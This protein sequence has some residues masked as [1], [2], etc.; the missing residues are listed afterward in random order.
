MRFAANLGW[1]FQE[2]PFLDRFAAARRAG[3]RGVEFAQPYEYP[4]AEVAARLR[5]NDLA[6]VLINLPMGDKAKGDF[7]IACRPGREAEFR[8]GVARGIEYAHSI[9]VPKLNCISGTAKPGEDREA[10]RATLVSNLRLAAREFKAAGLELVIE[11]INTHDIPG[12]FLSRSPEALPLIE[13]VGV[14]NLGLQCDLYHTVMMGDDPAAILRQCWP[15]IRH[16]QFADAPGRGEPG[17]GRIDFAPL[18]ALIEELGYAGWVSAEYRP[19]KPTPETVS[20][21]LS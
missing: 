6:C 7:G 21:F 16:I 18:F 9:G 5:D 1:L 12:F 10:M 19:S 8:E 2:H 4:A 13:E 3:F 17:T 14:D 20:S 11:P 15:A